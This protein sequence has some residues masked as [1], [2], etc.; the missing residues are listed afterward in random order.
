MKIN[1]PT[2]LAEPS[3]HQREQSQDDHHSARHEFPGFGELHTEENQQDRENDVGDIGL[4]NN[5]ARTEAQHGGKGD[6][7]DQRG[8]ASSFE[9][10]HEPPRDQKDDVNPENRVWAQ[11]CEQRGG[12]Q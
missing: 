6:R 1:W 10:S 3:E 4:K 12:W 11:E 7:R 5:P 2:T 9:E 8:A